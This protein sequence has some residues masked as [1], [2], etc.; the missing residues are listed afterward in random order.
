MTG[1]PWSGPGKRQTLPLAGRK[2]SAALAQSGVVTI[3]KFLDEIVN[4]GEL[5]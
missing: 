1:L 2:A 3:W 5:C 4:A